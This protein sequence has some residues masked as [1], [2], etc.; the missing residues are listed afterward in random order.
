MSIAEAP[1]VPNQTVALRAR[2]EVALTCPGCGAS[3]KLRRVGGGVSASRFVCE[4]YVSNPYTHN[5]CRF[6]FLVDDRVLARFR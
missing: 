6:R 3:G 1:A 4:A 5:E 2:A